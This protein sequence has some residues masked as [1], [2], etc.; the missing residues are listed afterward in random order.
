M[1]FNNQKSFM[2]AVRSG[3]I[4]IETPKFTKK[5][6]DA[7]HLVKWA[8]DLFLWVGIRGGGR[9][10]ISIWALPGKNHAAEYEFSLGREQGSVYYLS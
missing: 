1:S 10:G 7:T 6:S 4:E 2:D 8:K 9:M 5:V 3:F